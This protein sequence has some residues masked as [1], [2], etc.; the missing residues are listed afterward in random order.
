MIKKAGELSVLC[1]VE[2]AL[3]IFS[4]EGKLYQFP[5]GESLRKILDRYVVHAHEEA[6]VCNSVK[7]AQQIDD[8]FMGIWKATSLQEIVQRHIEGQNIKHLNMTQLIQ[9]ERKLDSILKQTRNRKTQ[10]I[11]DTVAALLEKG[12]QLTQENDAMEKKIAAGNDTEFG[13]RVDQEY[14]HFNNTCEPPGL[15]Q[16]F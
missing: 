8:E 12:K 4:P 10:V 11:D 14:P 15:L 6:A 7:E 16:L 1:D 13:E 3:L 2:L 9:L 5:C